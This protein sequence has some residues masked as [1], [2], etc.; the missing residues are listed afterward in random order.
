MVAPG[1]P[2]LLDPLPVRLPVLDALAEVLVEVLGRGALELD[3]LE[4]YAEVGEVR[5]RFVEG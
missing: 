3:C 5:S 1:S 2:C 4:G